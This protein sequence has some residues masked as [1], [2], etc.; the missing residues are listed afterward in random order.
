MKFTI[1]KFLI[2]F[3]LLFY[4]LSHSQTQ[5]RFSI[6]GL[7]LDET[8]NE[9]IPMVNVFLDGTT[10]GTTTDNEGRFAIKH[11]PPGSYRVIAS[12]IGFERMDKSIILLESEV[13]KVNFVLPILSYKLD[14]V[15]ITTE[16][17]YDWDDNYA[18]FKKNFLG[19]SENSDL[20][21]IENKEILEF[22]STKESKLVATAPKALNILNNALGYRVLFDL[23][24]F[25]LSRDEEVA[26]WGNILFKE[27]STEEDD[28]KETWIENRD[29][30]YFGS[31]R[32]FLIS[33]CQNE[34][35][36]NGYFTHEVKYPDWNDIRRQDYRT[37][38]LSEIVSHV[39]SIERA[40]QF[41][42][43]I[44]VTYMEEWEESEFMLYRNYLGSKIFKELN[45]QTS[46]IKLPYGIAM[47]D[48]NGNI[49]D[50]YKTIKVYGYWGWQ[51]AS[52]LLPTDY[53]PI[54]EE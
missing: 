44:M 5:K 45:Y 54:A 19:T 47:F 38:N 21:T 9:A 28:I 32:H 30:A 24:E 29:K 33:L 39:T 34:L 35:E 7:V 3:A 51:K 1:L 31:F 43:Y 16:R 50:N 36:E 52:D 40:L 22:H 10:Y 20:C 2:L 42:N 26:F 8:N 6:I 4:N 49:V 17:D 12:M 23:K 27:L 11:L 18:L 15:N 14:Q 37:P 53:C 25:E 46:W 13:T 41:D 48:I